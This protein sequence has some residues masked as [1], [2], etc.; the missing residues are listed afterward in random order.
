MTDM[1]IPEPEN[2]ADHIATLESEDKIRAALREEIS[3][4]GVKTVGLSY[5]G[6]GDEGNAHDPQFATSETSKLNV[7]GDL[8]TRFTEWAWE[9]ICGYH[10]GFENNEGGFG[11]LTWDMASGAINLDHNDYIQTSEQTLH[12]GV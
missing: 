6:G 11:Y 8:E 9:F 10:G 2:L 3:A 12:E 1:Q 7:P 5:D 4:L